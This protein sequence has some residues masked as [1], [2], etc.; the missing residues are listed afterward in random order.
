MK[1]NLLGVQID[2]LTKTQ[3]LREIESRLKQDKPIFIATPYS[4]SIVAAQKDLE[5]RDVL[6]SADI[7]LPDGIGILW[8]AKFLSNF[9]PVRRG[10]LRGGRIWYELVKSLL[11]II[12][13]PSY[14]RSPIPEKIS[15]SEFIWDLAEL[16]SQ[17]NYSIFLLG[18]FGDTPEKAAAKLKTKFP[19]LKIAGHYSPPPLRGERSGE[20][21]IVELIN[22]SNADFLFVA[23]GPIRQEKWIYENLPNLRVNPVTALDDK[24]SE[25]RLKTGLFSK[26]RSNGVKLAIGLGGTFDY[27]AGKR[28]YRAQF[29]AST[30]LEWLW[31]LLSQPRR[32]GRI[33]RGVLG[34]IWYCFRATVPS[35]GG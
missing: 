8:A 16:A 18:G 17:N 29:W 32:A 24:Y 9:S 26:G 2:N 6:N 20:G 23:L 35:K 34:L 31:R 7:A 10:R 14:I 13:N 15:G 25:N 3:V 28:P 19:N 12:F 11:A 30:G 27:L 22:N 5:F 21:E 33:L 4:E 1:I